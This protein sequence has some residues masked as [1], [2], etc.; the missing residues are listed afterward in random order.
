MVMSI[1]E[2]ITALEEQLAN[3][4]GPGSVAKKAEI[5]AKIDELKKDD[6]AVPEENAPAE[7]DKSEPAVSRNGPIEDAK[8]EQFP[9]R[10][11]PK[12]NEWIKVTIEQVK[13]AENDGSLM[14]FDPDKMVAL[15]RGK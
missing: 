1:Q 14:G 2:E 5:Q 3:T 15:I 9:G 8:A 4:K 11:L 7:E 10:R 12:A 6:E 13:A